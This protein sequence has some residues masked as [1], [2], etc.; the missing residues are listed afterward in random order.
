MH[1]S[2]TPKSEVS[3][4]RPIVFKYRRRALFLICRHLGW[5]DIQQGTP[6][7][8]MRQR[9]MNAGVDPSRFDIGKLNKDYMDKLREKDG[10]YTHVTE[11]VMFPPAPSETTLRATSDEFES[12]RFHQVRSLCK[13]RGIRFA[14]TDKRDVLIERLKAH[15][16]D[17]A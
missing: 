1:P 2:L 12:M 16:K 17:T 7:N 3:D 11:E 14:R 15:G 9:L 13:E 5:D 8:E 4:D 6:A 10:A